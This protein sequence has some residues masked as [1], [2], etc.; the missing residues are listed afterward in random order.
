MQ[1]RASSPQQQDWSGGTGNVAPSAAGVRRDVRLSFPAELFKEFYFMR[2][3]FARLALVGLVGIGLVGCGTS[4]G[5]TLQ[6]GS[7]PNNSGG[8][9]IN[10]T[11][12]IGAPPLGVVPSVMIDNGTVAAASSYVGFNAP[13][14]DVQNIVQAFSDPPSAAVP[15]VPP[16]PSGPTPSQ[17]TDNGSHAVTVTGNGTTQLIMRYAGA[18]PNLTYGFGTAG[19]VG[20]FNYGQIIA[21]FAFGLKAN[22]SVVIGGTITAGDTVTITLNGSSVTYTVTAA[23]TTATIAAAL[24]AAI[25]GS[26]AVGPAGTVA[27]TYAWVDPASAVTVRIAAAAPGV[28]ALGGTP[29]SGNTGNFITLA[30]STSGGATETATPSGATLAGGTASTLP[31]LTATFTSWAIE[32]VGNGAS[33]GPG[34]PAATYDVRLNCTATA[35]GNSQNRFVCG[36]MPAYGAAS[37]LAPTSGNPGAGTYNVPVNAVFPGAAGAFTPINPTM[38]V[39]L[40]FGTATLPGATANPWIDYIYAAQ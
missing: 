16:S 39:V 23:D 31:A 40:N 18:L 19:N 25:N 36:P 12:G 34:S 24:V 13:T 9:P 6:T 15:L 26:A 14:A 2:S 4:N 27:Q 7:V 30:T 21:H 35:V 32:L 5:T 20:T 8:G 28:G 10:T 38:Y 3:L 29:P 1:G 17:A 33:P 11:N 22:G 37:N